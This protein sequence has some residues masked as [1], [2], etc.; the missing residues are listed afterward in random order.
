MDKDLNVIALRWWQSLLLAPAQLQE[1]GI[2]AAPT[3]FKARLK[4]CEN[5]DAVMLTEGFRALWL[6][7]PAEVIEHSKA[8]HIECWATIAAALVHVKKESKTKFALAA[9]TKGEADKAVVSELRFAQ[10]QNAKTP[11][12]F[13]RRLRR[14]L[15]QVNNEVSVIDLIADIRQ[16]FAEQ[17]QMQPRKADKRISVRWAMDYYRAAAGKA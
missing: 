8:Q 15:Q 10:L 11:D 7:L 6:A 16:W 12:E 13:L 1:K 3:A 5:I 14:I 2:K 4:R 17:N 9:G